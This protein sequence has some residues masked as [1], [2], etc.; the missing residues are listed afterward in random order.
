VAFT[1]YRF[2]AQA[3]GAPTARP[4]AIG[5]FLRRFRL[6]VLP[7]LWNVLRGEMALVGPRADRPECAARLDVLLPFYR[8]RTV[9]KPGIT[10]WAQINAFR[11][12]MVAD[13]VRRLEYDLYYVKNFSASLDLFVIFRALREAAVSGDPEDFSS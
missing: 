10:G 13:E 1:L 3:A 4:P 8:Q 2:R 12:E 6:D 11:D 9:V 7:Q 5:R